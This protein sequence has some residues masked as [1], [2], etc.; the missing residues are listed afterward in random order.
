[1]LAAIDP[2]ERL[3][4]IEDTLEESGGVFGIGSVWFAAD[5]IRRGE[6]AADLLRET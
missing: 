6:T 2:G 1:V 3:V 4:T 5:A